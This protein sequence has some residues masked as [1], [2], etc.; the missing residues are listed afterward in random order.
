ML[1]DGVGIG[2]L[3]ARLRG[4]PAAAVGKDNVPQHLPPPADVSH[5]V[6]P[7]CGL[8]RRVVVVLGESDEAV[9]DRLG[10][11][12]RPLGPAQHDLVSPHYDLALDQFL[13]PPQ[14]RVA[15]PEDLEHPPRRY[16]ELRLY[17][18]VRSSSFFSRPLS[19]VTLACAR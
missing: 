13:D 8:R 10:S 3:V 1:A 5:L 11:V 2:L 14:D 15:L 19:A 17:P 6:Q 16:Y 4:D 12:N 7:L 18:G 9:E